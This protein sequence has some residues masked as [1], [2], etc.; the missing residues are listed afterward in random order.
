MKHLIGNLVLNLMVII[1]GSI[2][3]YH[4]EESRFIIGLIITLMVMLSISLLVMI[5][6]ELVSRK[7]RPT[8]I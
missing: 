5:R 8:R 2:L 7:S 6:K 3:F 1:F 4:I